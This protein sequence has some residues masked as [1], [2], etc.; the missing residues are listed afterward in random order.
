[1]V[2]I[3]VVQWNGKVKWNFF[4]GRTDLTKHLRCDKTCVLRLRRRTKGEW[5]LIFVIVD[6][7]GS[8][9]YA[10]AQALMPRFLYKLT[11]Y[12][13]CYWQRGSWVEQWN[14]GGLSIICTSEIW[15]INCLKGYWSL[16][17][18]EIIGMA[19]LCSLFVIISLA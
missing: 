12:G 16:V 6:L 15:I 9:I 8:A 17:T 2:W 3:L 14:R 13:L 10:L 5:P 19:Y 7:E 18:A 11:I 1:M 4:G